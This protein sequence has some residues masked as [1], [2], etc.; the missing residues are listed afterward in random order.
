MCVVNWH[1][2][3]CDNIDVLELWCGFQAL[4]E[5][6]GVF[7]VVAFVFYWVA[8]VFVAIPFA[9]VVIKVYCAI[10]VGTQNLL[11]PLVGQYFFVGIGFNWCGAIKRAGNQHKCIFLLWGQVAGQQSIN[12]FLNFLKVLFRY[13]VTWHFVQILCFVSA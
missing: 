4:F 12:A 13:F 1:N 11:C 10:D 9:G 6:L 3:V 7:C 2:Y 8:H 5:F